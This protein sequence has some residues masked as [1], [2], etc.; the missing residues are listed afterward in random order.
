MNGIKTN[1]SHVFTILTDILREELSFIHKS[2]R[3]ED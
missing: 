3:T 1:I 2:T